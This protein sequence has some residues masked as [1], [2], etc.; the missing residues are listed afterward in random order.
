[1]S[2]RVGRE[3]HHHH[4]FNCAIGAAGPLGQT[5]GPTHASRPRRRVGCCAGFYEVAAR[6]AIGCE[7]RISAAIIKIHAAGGWRSIIADPLRMPIS[8]R[9]GA[10]MGSHMLARC[11]PKPLVPTKPFPRGREVGLKRSPAITDPGQTTGCN[12]GNDPQ[13]NLPRVCQ[14]LSVRNA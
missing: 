10:F 1:M 9:S 7:G 3:S 6:A 2:C 11:A 12:H 4:D 14:K 5:G 8:N 13:R